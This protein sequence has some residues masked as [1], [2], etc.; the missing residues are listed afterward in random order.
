MP[1]RSE[2]RADPVDIEARLDELERRLGIPLRDRRVFLQA[3]THSS[4]S[5]E[6][7]PSRFPSNE[8]LEFL[9]DAVVNLSAAS[10]VCDSLPHAPEGALTRRRTGLVNQEALARRAKALGL[11][12]LV[13]LGT[14]AERSGGRRRASLLCDVFEAVAGAIYVTAGWEAA[15]RFLRAQFESMLAERAADGGMEADEAAWSDAKSRFQEYAQAR[16][17]PLPCYRLIAKEGPPHRPLFTVE[18]EWRGQVYGRGQGR[19][20]RQAEQEAA[21]EALR[22]LLDEERREK[23]S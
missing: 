7:G 22:R 11:D 2:G 23:G 9:G 17:E 12:R 16:G 21:E 13:L 3:L 18:V 4:F 6:W 10:F 1:G 19:S 20:R 15:D 8:R 5:H 14:G